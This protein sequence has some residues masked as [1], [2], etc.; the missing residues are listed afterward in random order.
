MQA[1]K[2]LSAYK[3]V[4]V[5]TSLI[6]SQEIIKQD[7]DERKPGENVDSSQWKDTI[8]YERREGEYFPGTRVRD[9]HTHYYGW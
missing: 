8:I 6:L 7:G 4:V 2:V 1:L 3:G 5:V 9:T